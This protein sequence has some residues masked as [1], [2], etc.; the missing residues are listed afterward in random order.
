MLDICENKQLVMRYPNKPS[1]GVNIY[2]N[3]YKA[4]FTLV[5]LCLIYPISSM[6][7]WSSVHAPFVMLLIKF[8][9][10]HLT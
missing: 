5:L 8:L 6:S 2:G 3:I 1:P 10:L 7:M 9:S 4:Q